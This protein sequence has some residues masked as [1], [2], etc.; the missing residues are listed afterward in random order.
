MDSTTLLYESLYC[1]AAARRQARDVVCKNYSEIKENQKGDKWVALYDGKQSLS[2]TNLPR[3]STMP[4]RR[5]FLSMQQA[6]RPYSNLPSEM[7]I[8]NTPTLCLF[9]HSFR[10]WKLNSK[11]ITDIKVDYL[12]CGSN[13]PGGGTVYLVDCSDTDRKTISN[14]N[15]GHSLWWPLDQE[16]P[17]EHL[18]VGG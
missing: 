14:Y 16:L 13:I 18:L 11:A 6:G 5:V 9:H 2:H 8:R 12:I 10:Q 1:K 17:G 7:L 3:W 4:P 15:Y